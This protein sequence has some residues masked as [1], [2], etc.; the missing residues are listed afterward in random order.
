MN[1]SNNYIYKWQVGN[2][3]LLSLLGIAM[4]VGESVHMVTAGTSMI[5][6]ESLDMSTETCQAEGSCGASLEE[7]SSN[8]HINQAKGGGDVCADVQDDCQRYGLF[9]GGIPEACRRAY[10]DMAQN[11]KKSCQFCDNRSPDSVENV[12]SEMPLKVEGNDKAKLWELNSMSDDYMYNTVYQD[13]KFQELRDDCLN[14]HELCLFWASI[15]ECEANPGYMQMQCAPSCLSCD[16]LLFETRCPFDAE[17]PTIWRQGHNDLNNMFLRLVTNSEYQEKYNPKTYS[18][19]DPTQQER[20]EFGIIDGPWV[21]VLD[22]FLSEEECKIMID[23]GATEGYERSR[24][25]GEKLYD[26]TYGGIESKGRTSSNAWCVEDCWKHETTQLIHE[27]IQDLIQIP[28]EN[29]EYLQLLKYEKGQFYNQH[30]DY[31][32]HHLDRS[33]GVRILTVFLYLNDVEAGGGT[34]FP[35]LNQT[36]HPKRGRALLW[37]SVLNDDPDQKDNLTE[38]EALPVEAGVKYGANAWVHQR[39]FKEP[40]SKGCH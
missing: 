19:P 13:E 31:I 20:E 23:L 24:D 2:L 22:D 17:E 5:V 14:R 25:V 9:R 36:V 1:H 29:Y 38:H 40:W 32:E 4:V 39:D 10:V 21:V 12:Y 3:C 27:R 33:P 37:P 34:H 7:E 15:G 30:H 8:M 26:G 16:H 18:K 28:K 11:C 35:L 6:D